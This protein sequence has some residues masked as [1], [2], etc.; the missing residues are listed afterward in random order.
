MLHHFVLPNF[1]VSSCSKCSS[2]IFGSEQASDEQNM[3]SAA[4]ANG[5]RGMP[6]GTR[7][8]RAQRRTP[9]HSHQSTRVRWKCCK[10]WDFLER[11]QRLLFERRA[12][13]PRL[14]S[15]FY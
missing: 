10:V 11:G 4:A 8:A 1:I 15:I 7:A 6:M 9:Q 13:T 3:A 12:I 14:Q 5:G 2:L